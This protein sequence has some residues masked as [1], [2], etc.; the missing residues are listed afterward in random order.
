MTVAAMQNAD[1]KVC[2]HMAIEKE[3]LDQ[4]IVGRD[5]GEVLPRT[6]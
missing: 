2:A 6:A 4:L 3:M 1:M 5:P